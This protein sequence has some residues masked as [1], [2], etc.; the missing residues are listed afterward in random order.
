MERGVSLG[1]A[2][3]FVFMRKDPVDDAVMFCLV[4]FLDCLLRSHFLRFAHYKL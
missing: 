2:V 4:C 3:S 1:V